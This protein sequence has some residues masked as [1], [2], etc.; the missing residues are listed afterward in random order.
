[1]KYAKRYLS[2]SIVLLLMLSLLT[3]SV[4]ANSAQTHWEGVD[5]AG[6]MVR[7]DDSPIIVEKELLTFDIQAF[8]ENYYRDLESY[9]AYSGKVTAEYSFYNP[10]DYAVSATLLFPLAVSQCMPLMNIMARILKSTTF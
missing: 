4:S 9:L 5:S 8:P 10:A 7:E 2:L 1:M 6:A 3:V